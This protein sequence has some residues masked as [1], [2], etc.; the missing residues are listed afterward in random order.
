LSTGVGATG[1]VSVYLLVVLGHLTLA[2]PVAPTILTVIEQPGRVCK[3]SSYPPARKKR[4][5]WLRAGQN[6]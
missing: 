1:S 3:L 2:E 5:Y 6:I 4:I